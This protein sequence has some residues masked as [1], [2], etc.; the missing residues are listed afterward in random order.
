MFES[1]TLFYVVAALVYVAIIGL[2]FFFLILKPEPSHW[3]KLL[4]RVVTLI[5][6]VVCVIGYPFV[7]LMILSQMYVG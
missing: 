5:I 2:G 6:W 7:M 1:V 3:F 4:V